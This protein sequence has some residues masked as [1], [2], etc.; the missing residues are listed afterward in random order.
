MGTIENIC[1]FPDAIAFFSSVNICM[2]ISPQRYVEG[3]TCPQVFLSAI[4]VVG[5][6]IP[7]TIT[8][9]LCCPLLNTS[10]EQK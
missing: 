6:V 8:W 7:Y 1:C 2:H 4:N 3:D 9:V 10:E 5:A